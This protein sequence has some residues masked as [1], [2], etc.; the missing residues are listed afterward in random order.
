M[1]VKDQI[2]IKTMLS[3]R[4]LE[5]YVTHLRFPQY[6][7]LIAD[8]RVD[9]THPITALV[10]QN[11]TNKSSVLRALYGVPGQNN[12]GNLWF[13]T[14][15]DPIE[16][17]A[18]SPNCFVYGYHNEEAG[19]NTE[20][21]KTRI[22]KEDD[23]D[24]W[25]P[26]RPIAK[27]GMTPFKRDAPAPA[28]G[29][30]TRWKSIRKSVVYIDFRAQLSAFDK[31]FYHGQIKNKI[32][33]PKK[34][35]EL[36]RNRSPQLKAAIDA[37]HDSHIWHVE[38]IINKEN[39]SLSTQEVAEISKILGRDYAE[40]KII[41][42]GLYFSDG[43]TAQM[44]TSALK[45]TEAFAGSGE[46]SVVALVN[47]VSNAKLNSLILLDEPEVSLHPGAQERL[48]DFLAA[49]IKTHKHQIV[50]STHSPA[51]IRQLPPDAIK[52]LIMD[53]ASGKVTLPNQSSLPDEAFFH[54]GEPINGK[55][56]IVVEDKLAKAM[57][58]KVLR[59]KG[60]AFMAIFEVVY[61]PGGAKTMWKSYAPSYA[62]SGRK[63]VLF[64]LDGDQNISAIPDPQTLP[65]ASDSK[66]AQLIKNFT[67]VEIDFPIDGGVAGG[68]QQQLVAAQRRCHWQHLK[69]YRLV[70]YWL[71]RFVLLP[72]FQILSPL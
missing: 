60:E 27:Y 5:P 17:G 31:F 57:V 64:L 14:S 49:S 32:I 30:K 25:E 9:F 44:K 1:S 3:K 67:G 46:F 29:S 7:N 48:M 4:L 47:A 37:G 58:E 15:I 6:K 13:S 53:S 42:H 33:D 2:T 72:P 52:L 43:Y 39:R 19:H 12:V 56:I 50:I 65:T 40:I 71:P 34:R 69:K 18:T 26:S 55:K 36:I 59:P 24:Y 70:K 45:Y 41:R 66:L 21:L 11:G 35:K 38:R 28:G 63:D 10:G 16:E 22:K 20:V 62:A 54:L 61:F 8:L 23:P 68:D 51:L